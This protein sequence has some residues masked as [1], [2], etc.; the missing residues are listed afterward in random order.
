MYYGTTTAVR[1]LSGCCMPSETILVVDNEANQLTAALT[2][3][4]Y[5][6]LTA[7]SGTEA[8]KMAAAERPRLV[9]LN[10]EGSSGDGF[11]ICRQLKAAPATQGI[12]V[13]MLTGRPSESEPFWGL[14]TGADAYVTAP[15]AADEVL[16]R[17]NRLV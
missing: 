11:H 14:R 4:G 12:R 10:T 16:A 1:T 17:V 13:L 2:G 5:R 3:R 7:A 8:I 15:F 9:V 6:V